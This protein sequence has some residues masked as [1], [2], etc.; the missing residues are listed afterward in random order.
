[1]ARRDDMTLKGIASRISI[2]LFVVIIIFL[3]IL[4]IEAQRDTG[5]YLLESYNHPGYYIRH[6]NFLADLATISTTFD[7]QASTFVVIPSL[8]DISEGYVSF[9]SLNYPG[10]YLKNQDFRL[11]LD[12]LMPD[13][14]FREDASFEIVQGLADE[15][16][17]SFESYNHPGY[18][19]RNRDFHL[20][21]EQNDRSQL[22]KEDATFRMKDPAGVKVTEKGLAQSPEADAITSEVIFNNWNIGSVDNSPSSATIF[23][24]SEPY[25]IT[26]IDTYHWND[27][28]GTEAGGTV[29]LRD[30]D[31]KEYGPWQVETKSGQGGVP[32][33]WWIAHPNEK[34][35]AGAYEI[36]DSD[37]STWSQNSESGGCGFSKVEGYP[38]KD[39]SA[40][41]GQTETSRGSS[42]MGTSG[43]ETRSSVSVEGPM[44]NGQSGSPQ[45]TAE[46]NEHIEIRGQVAT[47]DF[48]WTPQ[49]FAGFYYDID[50][51]SGTESLSAR[52]TDDHILSGSSPYGLTYQTTAQDGSFK[53]KD[54]GSYSV[55]GFLGKKCFAGY[56][57]SNDPDKNFLSKASRDKNSLRKG[58][59]EEVLIDDDT[60]RTITSANPLKLAD[61]CELAV[62]SIDV[63]GNKVYVELTKNGKV[64]DSKDI[65]PSVANAN[66]ADKTYC[67]KTKVG[68]IT[69]I[70]QIA[71]HFKNAFR[72][73]DNDI[74][75]VDGV[76]QISDTAM[77]IKVGQTY[78]KMSISSVNEDA[79]A[80][81]NRDNPITLS[82][83]KDTVL[84]QDIHIMTADQSDITLDHPLRYC[85]SKL[86]TAP[87]TYD[88]RGT[89]HSL[90][91]DSVT[92]DPQ[93][94]A[95][96]YYDINSDTG[97]ETI[98]FTPTGSDPASKILSD[99][100]DPTT[101]N[102]GAVYFTQAQLAKFKFEPWGMYEVIGFLADKYFAAYNNGRT[103]DMED[104]GETVPF[105]ADKST[106]DNLMTNLQVCKVLMDDDIERTI[107]TATPLVLQEGYQLG[108]KSIDTDGNQ[109]YV[110]LS[111][112]GVVVDSKIIH[113]SIENA[114]MSDKTY[115][116]HTSIGDTRN[117]VQ[118][119]VHFKNAFR[120]ADTNI[121][122]VDG[123]FQISDAP[124]SI[125]A[126]TQYD[127]MSIRK[128]DP[129]GM[130]IKMDNNVPIKL[131]E[132]RDS[133]L[134][135]NIHIRTADQ[136]I[137]DA[138][139]PLRYYIYTT[140]TPGSG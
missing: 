69:D 47:G 70:V 120:G 2:A 103:A 23:T 100:Q 21:L 95:G 16:E 12:C 82:R 107:T 29:A 101:G 18:Y 110:E 113:P 25:M 131:N 96:F 24:I 50:T 38:I 30:D 84:M 62:K 42:E 74:A 37:Q 125:K 67:Y 86:C 59:V 132:N 134:M 6:L 119:A 75:T 122:T 44:S 91:E 130:T 48:T 116:Y 40:S 33:A 72:G 124:I 79:I 3:P 81:D 66:M 114:Q 115:Y 92:W 118:I 57:E 58:Q 78:D 7:K 138:N 51:N 126:D 54:W 128:V 97:T 111:K 139:E 71:V 14:Q 27:G 127:K 28:S 26:Y 140:A 39:N 129:S 55:I 77:P 35:P 68:D 45:H 53:F 90:G 19:I 5:C 121:A 88:I 61:G 83:N 4:P 135:Q 63:D 49:N 117:I 52:V 80:M 93:T 15:S 8:A 9:D 13:Q 98:T 46:S 99:K 73:A 133:V 85:I 87:D 20:Y 60:E 105:L 32:N 10:H 137:I 1:M 89:V 112:R 94:F 65:Q 36:I 109:V 136:D 22:F 17:V 43:P 106:N 102:R 76:F 56:L 11:E 31:G 64:V 108:V 123:V 104:A 41:E 34:I